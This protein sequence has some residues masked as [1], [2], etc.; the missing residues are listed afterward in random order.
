MKIW[1]EYVN[2]YN[3][4][5][6]FMRSVFKQLFAVGKFQ[7]N[8]FEFP[9]VSSTLLDTSM[10]KKLYYVT[11][12]IHWA[13]STTIIVSELFIRFIEYS[14]IFRVQSN[15][16]SLHFEHNNAYPYTEILFLKY[17]Q[18]SNNNIDKENSRP[19]LKCYNKSYIQNL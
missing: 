6:K 17:L 10:S 9:L 16:C 1:I 13:S 8:A 12:I 19:C 14:V 7:I 5:V 11:Q 2:I 4:K 15:C 3:R 18:S